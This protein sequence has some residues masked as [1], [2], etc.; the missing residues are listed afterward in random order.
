[1]VIRYFR[2]FQAW[3]RAQRAKRIEARWREFNRALQAADTAVEQLRAAMRQA[4]LEQCAKTQTED[5]LIPEVVVT[6]GQQRMK[7]PRARL[8]GAYK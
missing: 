4:W 6:V 5:S 8:P 7:I 3:R 2:V 1:M